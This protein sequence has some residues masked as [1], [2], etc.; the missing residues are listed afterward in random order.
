MNIIRKALLAS[1]LLI[2]LIVA[3]PSYATFEK[4]I[5]ITQSTM[6]N[7]SRI[8]SLV[9]Q[10]KEVGITTF[11]VDYDYANSRYKKNIQML[12]DNDIKYVARVVIF[13]D[14]G[15]QEQVRSKS[16]WEKKY[17]L[18]DAAINLGAKEIQLDYIRYKASRKNSS[19]NAED[20]NNVIKWFK[21]KVAEKGVPLQ[22][23]VFG[24]SSFGESKHI[25]QSPYRFASTVNTL[26]PMV[27]PS[28]FYPIDVHS[29]T[30]YKTIES[31]LSALKAQFNGHPPVKIIPYIEV[32]NYK[33]Q[34]TGQKGLKYVQEQMRA[35]QDSGV[36]GWYA[37]SANNKYQTLFNAMKT[38]NVK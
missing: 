3:A 30:P 33:Y 23:D 18:I 25:G 24:I 38:L 13:P 9:K 6:E 29:A 35:V 11:V 19:N 1:L 36:N 32:H 21:E 8:K 28:H 34:Y 20:I 12:K 31:S 22:I 7:E 37:W 15:T 4:G 17:K 5:Y 16:Y 14:G 27:Y 2:N 26:C 10:A